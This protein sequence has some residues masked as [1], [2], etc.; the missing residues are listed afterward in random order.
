MAASPVVGT[1]IWQTGSVTTVSVAFADAD[2]VDVDGLADVAQLHRSDVGDD[3]AEVACGDGG[4]GGDEQLS[5]AGLAGDA[6]GEVD[7]GAV[8][9]AVDDHGASVVGAGAWQAARRRARRAPA[10]AVLGGR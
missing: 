10:A 9:V 4:A 7:G 5:A 3:R 6:G 1:R 2:V 8:V